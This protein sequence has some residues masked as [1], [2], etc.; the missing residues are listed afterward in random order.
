M[1]S[2]TVRLVVHLG[3][4]RCG[5][6]A[7]AQYLAANRAALRNNGILV[8]GQQLDMESRPG[9]Q[10]RFFE[11]LRPVGEA[12]CKAFYDRSARLKEIADKEGA[13]TIIIGS[14]NLINR[15]GYNL[16]FESI[17]AL[18]DI[19]C[20]L[21]IRRQDDFMISAWP[22]WF[23]RQGRTVEQFLER[24]LS[25]MADWNDRLLP[26]E[27]SL[28]RNRITVRRYGSEYLKDG[29][30]TADFMATLG[31]N[32]AGYRKPD[33]RVNRNVDEAIV[34]MGSRVVDAF[35]DRH[36]NDFYNAFAYAIGEKPLKN[37]KGSTLLTYQQRVAIYEAYSLSNEHVKRKYFSDLTP[38]EPLFRAPEPDEVISL[39]PEQEREAEHEFLI[40][41]V[42]GLARRVRSLDRQKLRQASCGLDEKG[43]YTRQ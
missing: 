37:R 1:P 29:D 15:H 14:E 43:G 39:T 3:G 12:Q 33:D 42:Y 8:P 31:L 35:A 22:R 13:H 16:L 32:A 17:R 19:R 18:F 20:I 2:D 26:W 11:S 36:V 9:N 21:Y 27:Q 38:S 7:I 41:A 40:R 10:L 5:S 6:S 34:R 25:T 24:N 28:T 30:V 4:P 23:M